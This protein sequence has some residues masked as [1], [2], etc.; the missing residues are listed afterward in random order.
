MDVAAPWLPFGIAIGRMGDLVIADHLAGRTDL[1]F[2]FR[3][4]QIVD[5]GRT[6]GSPRPAGEVVHL[7]A[8]Y[9]L[10]VAAAV[11]ATLVI[12]RRTPAPP[13]DAHPPA[14]RP[15]RLRAL[16]LRLPPRRAPADSASPAASGR[17]WSWSWPGASLLGQRRRDLPL[18]A[19]STPRGCQLGGP[20]SLTRVARTMSRWAADPFGWQVV[21]VR[22]FFEGS[23]ATT[24]KSVGSTT[25]GARDTS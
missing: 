1:P 16:P 9:D 22:S 13:R 6:V 21:R 11:A 2:G 23:L 18:D 10:L 17:R 25:N 8:A 7:T 12:L 14:R 5:V 20:A 3:C 15:V 19:T 4:P 24:E